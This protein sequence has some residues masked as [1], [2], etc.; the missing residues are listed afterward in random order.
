[1]GVERTSSTGAVVPLRS[2]LADDPDMAELVS[3]FI[4][5]VGERINGL[6][7][8]VA[9]NDRKTL[10]RLSHQLKGAAGGYGY[11]SITEAAA[12]VER[13]ASDESVSLE[14][15]ANHV[16]ALITLCSRAA[17]G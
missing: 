16:E 8:A 10:A 17:A 6:E 11:P 9:E 5:E 4:S 15:L 13:S 3:F 14:D 2:M 1:M 12:V 7:R